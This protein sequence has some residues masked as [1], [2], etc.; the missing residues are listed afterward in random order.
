MTNGWIESSPWMKMEGFSMIL[1]WSRRA[2]NENLQ[3]HPVPGKRWCQNQKSR[4]CWFAFLAPKKH[5]TPRICLTRSEWQPDILSPSCGTSEKVDLSCEAWIVPRQMYSEHDNASSC[6]TLSV[7]KILAKD[8][9]MIL[10]QPRC[11]PDLASCDPLLFLRYRILKA[12][13]RFRR[14]RRLF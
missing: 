8:S 9:T 2:W 7:N 3:A 4:Q 1:S 14:L 6:K 5:S 13:K 11:S 10:K 12:W